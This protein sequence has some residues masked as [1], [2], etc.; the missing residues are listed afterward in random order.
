MTGAPSIEAEVRALIAEVTRRDASAIGSD[1]DLVER[2][3]V[4]SLQGLQ[5]LA[6]V[7][8]R[9]TVTLPDEDLIRLRTIGRIARVVERLHKGGKS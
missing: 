6:G 9:F 5:I 1:E 2:L 3:G 7:E 8:K 4:D